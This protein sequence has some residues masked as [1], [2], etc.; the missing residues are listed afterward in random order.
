MDYKGVGQLF[1]EMEFL[2]QHKFLPMIAYTLVIH[3]DTRIKFRILVL[4]T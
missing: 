2:L 1:D 4:I 3:N